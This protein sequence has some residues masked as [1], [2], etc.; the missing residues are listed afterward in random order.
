MGKRRNKTEDMKGRGVYEMTRESNTFF[1]W[2]KIRLTTEE[3]KERR[4]LETTKEKR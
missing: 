1:K 2:E 4:V 3:M